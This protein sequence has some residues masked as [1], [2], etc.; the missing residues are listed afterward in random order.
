MDYQNFLE[1]KIRIAEKTGFDIHPE[2]LHPILKP[3]QRDIVQWSIKGGRRGIFASF[4]LGKTIMQLETNRLIHMYKGGNVLFVCP[5]GVK[6]EFVKD[7]KKLGIGRIKYITNTDQLEEGLPYYITNYERIRKGDIDASKFIAVTFDEASC[8]RNLETDTTNA[9]LDTFGH[10][11]FRFV[12][13]ATPSPNRY[14]ELINYAEYLGIMDRGQALTRF[15]QR[16]ST[17]AGNLTLYKKREKEFWFWMSSW[18]V[19]I[20]K[21]SDLGYDDSG[22]VLPPLTIHRHMVSF[23]RATKVDRKTGQSTFIPDSSSSLPEAAKEKRLSLPHR[24]AKMKAIIDE[25]PDDHFITWHHLEH[26]RT[27]IQKILGDDCKSVFGSQSIDEKEKHIE[28]FSEGAFK[29]L[30]SKPSI[31]GSGCNFQYHCHNAIFVGINYEFNDFIQAVFRVYRFMQL[32]E[33]HLHLIFT[34]AELEILRTLEEKWQ[35]HLNLQSEMTSIIQD[36]GLNS[37]LYE[38]QLKREMF[39]GR[40]EARGPNWIQVNNDSVDEYSS[41][42]DCSIGLIVSSIPF[43][44]HYEYSENYNCFGHNE[45]NEKFF[46]QMDFLVP[47]LYRCLKPGRIAAIHVKDRIRYSYM[48]GTGFTSIDPFS[49]DTTQCFRKH[50]FHLLSRITIDTDVV[51]ENNSTYRLSWSEACKDMTKMGAGLPEYVLIFRKPPTGSENAYADEPVQHSKDQ[52][53]LARWQLDAHAHWKTSGERLIDPEYLKKLDL[54]DVLKAW[55]AIDTTERYD[56]HKHIEI[57]EKLDQVKMLPRTFMAIP[58]QA[59]STEIWD[60]VSRVNTLNGTQ[61]RKNLTKHICP[62]QLDIIERCIERYSNPGDVVA[63]PFNGIGSVVYQAVKM[64]RFGDGCELKTEY[65]KDSIRHAKSADA[66]M[67]AL[68]LF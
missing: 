44:N 5:L 40:Q 38:Y 63:D 21:P 65:W 4:G 13:T 43:G 68:T 49:D 48:N 27:E 36:F 2:D 35:E 53:T 47:H 19:F 30:S 7:G 25:S 46:E 56:Y 37:D 18:A 26:E 67:S 33:C 51:Q 24:V 28:G 58:P 57:C 31:L 29:Y 8:L 39:T 1:A 42:K 34:D 6:R 50:G 52:Y 10:V 59:L 54:S 32:H 45:T 15:F 12:H 20:T 64:G 14:L 55:K 3:H 17:T 22:Y 9:I 16:D 23:D 60:D 62:L 61:T 11:P 66:K 41:K